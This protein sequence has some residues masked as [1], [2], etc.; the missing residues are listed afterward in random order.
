MFCTLTQNHILPVNETGSTR[1]QDYLLQ[2]EDNI[3]WDAIIHL[4][5]E[6]SAHGIKIET[7]G[8]N[9]FHFAIII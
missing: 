8:A 7:V 1:V 5:L 6:D 4:G 9:V 2:N 3:I